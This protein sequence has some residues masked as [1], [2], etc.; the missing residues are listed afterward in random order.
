[1]TDV[2]TPLPPSPNGR[3]GSDGTGASKDEQASVMPGLRFADFLAGSLGDESPAANAGSQE[4]L[5][6]HPAEVSSNPSPVDD[7]NRR[8]FIPPQT[9]A[10]LFGDTGTDNLI[11][12]ASPVGGSP[13]TGKSIPVPIAEPGSIMLDRGPAEILI[14]TDGAASRQARRADA[15]ANSGVF[16]RGLY[17]FTGA[18]S[19]QSSPGALLAK[20]NAT[21]QARRSVPGFDTHDLIIRAIS[22]LPDRGMDTGRV[23]ANSQSTG[24]IRPNGAAVPGVLAGGEPLAP[25]RPIESSRVVRTETAEGAARLTDAQRLGFSLARLQNQAVQLSFQIAGGRVKVIARVGEM[26]LNEQTKL[27]TEIRSM[28]SRHGIEVSEIEILA[29]AS[30]S[31]GQMDGER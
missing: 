30:G 7:G 2:I 17:Q 28:L 13:N 14:Q 31:D 29:D 25:T 4:G 5:T 10:V 20:A 18:K 24:Q 27:K 16:G 11:T 1:M 15:F 22:S 6:L 19:D 8:G 12:G 26:S 23:K 21:D 3:H 9:V